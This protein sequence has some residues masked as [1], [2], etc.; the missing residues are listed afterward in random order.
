MTGAGSPPGLAA[1]PAPCDDA[2]GA[3]QRADPLAELTV[4][5]A[6][7][8]G[9]VD[10]AGLR[11]RVELRHDRQGTV[12]GYLDGRLVASSAEANRVI[13]A[14]DQWLT[15]ERMAAYP[16]AL[17]L[18]AGAVSL[19]GRMI[20][21]TGD[22]G[23]GKTTL[24]LHLLLAGEAYHCDEYVML[25]DGVAHPFP[26]RMHVKQGTVGMFPDLARLCRR[27][28]AYPWRAGAHYY[29]LEPAEI[30]RC[31]TVAPGRPA[32]IVHLTPDFG[33]PPRLASVA[34]VR[35]ASVLS[36]Q[37]L[38]ARGRLGWALGEVASLVR[39]TPCFG[40]TAGPL[41]ETAG[42][43]QDLAGDLPLPR[44]L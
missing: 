17:R 38:N 6:R 16:G 41:A 39:V 36:A 35:M 4:L 10:L 20:L 26:L 8:A 23:A 14:L 9:S 5:P 27:K 15:A 40:L 32:A 44:G 19:G 33:A 37:M 7:G 3:S 30:G 13:Q 31:W 42:Q 1:F 21:L 2:G 28:P 18:H 29:L 34:K 24:L 12:Q 11:R 25:R 43:L 22:S